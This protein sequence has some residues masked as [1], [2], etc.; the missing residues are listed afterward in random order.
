MSVK[1]EDIQLRIRVAGSEARKE[2]DKLNDEARKYRDIMKDTKKAHDQWA[3]VAEDNKALQKEY[4][5][6]AEKMNTLK[7]KLVGLKK[8]S[9]EFT[10]TQE[11]IAKVDKQ[12]K[13]MMANV[14]KLREKN[15]EAFEGF[16][17]YREAAQSLESVNQKLDSM[18]KKLDLNKMNMKELKSEI[19]SLSMIKETMDPNNQAFKETHDRLEAAKKRLTELRT[20]LSPFGQAVAN[21]KQ[22]MLGF[23][24]VLVAVMAVMLAITQMKGF[25]TSLGAMDDKMADVRK[26]TG[27]TK[28]EVIALRK[29]FTDLGTRTGTSDM[30]DMAVVAGQVG[31]AKSEVDDFVESM[32]K[33]NVALGDEFTGG[34]AEVADKMGKLRNIFVDIKSNHVDKDLLKIGNAIN[35]L[36]A[37]GAATAP[38]LQGFSSRIGGV[39]ITL[40]LG[41]DKVLG[42]SAALEEL[43]VTEE[44]GGT[45][46]VK[47]LQKMAAE[48]EKF[49][50]VA[51]YQ[52]KDGLKEFT[53]L[54]NNDLYTAFLKVIEGAQRGGSQATAFA[55]ILK[56][57]DVDGAGASEVVAKLGN[58]MELLESRVATA[59]KAIKETSSIQSEFTIKNSTLGAELDKLSKKFASLMAMPFLEEFAMKA[60]TG[61]NRMFDAVKQLPDAFSKYSGALIALATVTAMYYTKTILAVGATITQKTVELANLAVLKAKEYWTR[62]VAVATTLYQLAVGVVTGEIALATAAQLA[63]N[64]ALAVSPW[65]IVIGLVGAAAYAINEYGKSVQ[66]AI[67]IEKEYKAIKDEANKLVEEGLSLQ[68]RSRIAGELDKRTLEVSIQEAETLRN[69]WI[70]KETFIKTKFHD[71]FIMLDEL[72]KRNI[73]DYEANKKIIDDQIR[74]QVGMTLELV[75][76]NKEVANSYMATFQAKLDIINKEEKAEADKQTAIMEA[77]KQRQENEEKMK[78]QREK[79]LETAKENTLRH[80]RELRDLEISH[81]K[82]DELREQQALAEEIIRRKQKVQSELGD[83]DVKSKLLLAIDEDFRIKKKAITD[84]YD[85]LE[86]KAAKERS[87][88]ISAVQDQVYFSTL[89]R[90]DQELVSLQK[91]FEDKLAEYEKYGLDTSALTAQMNQAISQLLR[92][93]ADEE[94]AIEQEKNDKIAQDNQR[95]SQQRIQTIQ[96]VTNEL[97]GIFGNFNQTKSNLEQQDLNDF[98]H[99]QALRKF[100]LEKRLKAGKITQEEYNNELAKM[101][102]AALNKEREVRNAQAKRDK[103]AKT[104]EATVSMFIAIAKANEAGYP[105]ALF[106]MPLAAATGAAQIAAIQS[107]PAP[108]YGTGIS[109]GVLGGDSHAAP[110]GGNPVLDPATGRVIAKFEK[111]EALINK[112]STNENLSVIHWLNANP[113]KSLTYDVLAN[114][115]SWPNYQTVVT[116]VTTPSYAAGIS[117]TGT[118]NVSY[119]QNKTNGEAE[120]LVRLD[121]LISQNNQL[122]EAYR[123]FPRTLKSQVSIMDIDEKKEEKARID[124]LANL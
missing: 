11:D 6:L 105:A 78:K 38:G 109:P 108:E 35:V 52:G 118:G 94:I 97:S 92:Q 18:S 16:K 112:D 99:K 45:A 58:N 59:S 67:E 122:I 113:G 68:E 110:S 3:K 66:D 61:L 5:A 26:T 115:I 120:L 33:L 12:M 30:L 90:N 71:N 79:D 107:T 72:K 13:S 47:I 116:S 17:K 48:T 37:E 103:T 117:Q 65:G 23:N 29:E 21:V 49:A 95:A 56:D 31:T 111:G 60:V 77:A 123:N 85:D 8:G 89:S 63:F 28:D 124:K 40:G 69:T 15:K 4:T 119:Q 42:L 84:K 46:V 93:Q 27:M 25:V 102:Q 64:A 91:W 24:G 32:D 104:I 14:D 114:Q 36:S 106:L 9:K 74:R 20:G 87:D 96:N 34:A 19:R 2:M 70:D 100:D 75:Q 121:T 101:D 51:G 98:K 39:A 22:E 83:E 1:T 10:Q 62:A 54:V 86:K 80:L 41:T 82:D 73:S 44:R 55:G 53:D 76:S 57:L 7:E 43:N 50:E 81:I 88:A